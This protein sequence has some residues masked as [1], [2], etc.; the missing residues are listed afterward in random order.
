MTTGITRRDFMNGVAIGVLGA[1]GVDFS[2]ADARADAAPGSAYPPGRDGL[3]GSHPGSFEAAHRLRDGSRFDIT[4]TVVS[5]HYDLAV[6]GAGIS[7]LAAAHF[8]RQRRPNAR[9]LILDTN[10]DFGGHAKR[11][12][13]VVDGQ[14]LIGYGGT[15][16]IDGPA[17]KWDAAA[18]GLLKDLGI[19]VKRF[20]KAYDQEF[21][22]R[23]NLSQS[24]F[25]KRETFGVD[26][27]VRRS[28]GSWRDWDEDPHDE[29][30]LRAYLDQFPLGPR[31]RAQ[32]FEMY[33]SDRDVLPGKT[34]Q[35]RRAVLEHTSYR[36]FLKR[37]WDVDDE[38]LKF[39]QTR[40]HELWA[41]GIDAVP[42]S[43]TL[44]LP[45]LKAQRAPLG[46]EREEPYIYHFPDGNASIARMLVRKLVPSIAAGDSMDDIVL[47]PF[48]YAQLDRPEHPVRIRLSST[49]VDVRNVARGVEIAY[50]KGDQVARIAT[51][52]CVLACYHAMVPY[53][54]PEAGEEQRAALHENVRAP[55][56]Y[57]NVAVRNWHPWHKLGVFY[58]DNPGGTY[59]ASLDFPVGLGGYRFSADPSKPACL[60]LMHAPTSPNQGLNMREQYRAGRARLYAMSFA[61]FEREIRDEL[62]R[63]LGSAGFDF[64]RDVAAITVNRWPHGYAYTPT[65]LYDDPAHQA[66]IAKQARRQLGRIAIANSDSGW[67]A[68]THVAIDQA[69]R[70]IVELTAGTA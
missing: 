46:L 4:Q 55:L 36:D 6:V 24:V 34:A 18:K 19:D 67:D 70:A 45:G 20:N 1:A 33:W 56:V 64:D 53:L 8:Y 9:V 48:D 28:F 42:A 47:A 68:Y 52:D 16:S 41:V 13:F 7:G 57:V 25:F 40:T 27:L 60:H 65:P 11:N 61:D 38:I 31:A 59:S 37:Y 3:R 49:A 50:V 51:R 17:R 39:L 22:A 44:A 5:E 26:R 23:W 10:D 54:A 35:Q 29:Q 58:I 21:Y 43:E 2:R 63:M 62:G 66:R 30:S 32:L 14:T 12:E 69:H 15:Q